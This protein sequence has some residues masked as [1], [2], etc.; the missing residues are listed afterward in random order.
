MIASLLAMGDTKE[1]NLSAHISIIEKLELAG[2]ALLAV[3]FLLRPELWRRLWFDRVDPRPAALMRISFGLVVFTTFAVLLL[4]TGPLQYSTARY[5]F[6][7]DG[8]WLTDTA[9]QNYGGNLRH[10]WDAEHGFQHW[11]DIFTAVGDH[12]SLLHIR[13]DP[14]F[15][16]ALYGVMLASLLLMV[17]GV[18][19]RVTTVLSFVLVEWVYRYSP[20]FYTGG[21]TVIR[22]FM[23]LG[24]FADWGK[25]YS[26]D[27]LWARREAIFGRKAS[28]IPAFAKIPAWPMRLMMVQLAIIYCATGLLKSGATWRVGTALYYALCLD[29]FYRFP[30]IQATTIAQFLGILPVSTVVVH[31]WEMLFPLVLIGAA[32]NAYESERARGVWPQAALWRRLLSYAV[33]FAAWAAGAYLLGIGVHYFLPK[34]AIPQLPRAAVLPLFAGIGLAILPVAWGLM[35]FLRRF[36]PRVY[37]FVRT[38]ILGKRLWLTIGTGMHFGIMTSMNVGTFA[39]VM[40][41]LY[42][43]WLSGEEVEAFWR[44]LYSRALAPGE[45]GR[46]VRKRRFVAVLLTPVDWL[47]CRTSR[48]P[49]VVV[50]HPGEES[51]RRVAM[52]RLWDLGGRFAF[53]SD[54]DAPPEILQIRSTGTGAA[55]RGNEAGKMLLQVV[56]ALLPLR[57][58]WWVPGV[59]ALALRLLDQR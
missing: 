36:F 2:V 54:D 35:L 24:M 23:F 10:L 6:T 53:E 29:H 56:P 37:A 40:V 38:W 17:L 3:F 19:T 43:A 21:D 7:D 16:F 55:K 31:W 57:P 46:P 45:G 1:L 9:R 59:P 52:L 27:C 41:T 42:F 8:L 25:A 34:Q 50:H 44:Y 32:V 28:R 15:V 48:N 4:P 14:S 22:V 58:L 49:L 11:Y 18:W 39:P 30:A 12:F 26:L 20:V 5:L 51:V 33:F 47:L 13:S